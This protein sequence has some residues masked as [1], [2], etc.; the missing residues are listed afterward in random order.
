MGGCVVTS[1]SETKFTISIDGAEADLAA[2]GNAI[3]RKIIQDAERGGNFRGYRPGTIPP[4]LLPS[5]RAFAMDECARETILEAMQ[6]NEIRP[7]E[8]AR[9][10]MLI[11]RV[12]IPPPKPQKKSK[13]KKRRKN[14]TIPI[15]ETVEEPL[16][17]KTYDTMKEALKGGWEPGQSFSFVATNCRGQRVDQVDM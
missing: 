10:E 8:S 16:E 4:H 12:S 7:F 2:F 9:E 5:Y 1:E 11:E 14:Q 6:Q 17:W 15:Q 3:Y 13:K